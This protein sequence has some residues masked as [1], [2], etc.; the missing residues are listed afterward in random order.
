MKR[1]L[2]FLGRPFGWYWKRLKK[3]KYYVAGSALVLFIIWYQCLPDQLFEDP[4]C[5]VLTDENN[6]I[7]AARI[8]DDGQWRFPA[9]TKVPYKFKK[10][11]I[12]FEDRRFY[13]HNGFS[14]RGF[15]R[16]LKQNINAGKIVSGG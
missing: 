7:L 12:Q 11:I 1:F 8:A 10:A 16:A 4:T 6:N 15:G 3:Y 5:T 9:S 14:F 13:D 2:T